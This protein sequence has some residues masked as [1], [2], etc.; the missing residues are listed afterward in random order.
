[1]R[2]K[3]CCVKNLFFCNFTID[4]IQKKKKNAMADAGTKDEKED[5]AGGNKT[6]FLTLLRLVRK[7][8]LSI[9]V[10]DN[11]YENPMKMRNSVLEQDFRVFGNYPGMRTICNGRTQTNDSTVFTTKNN[12]F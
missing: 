10:V 5:A 6:A 8:S 1:M 2:K 11:F 12:T 3:K 4:P 9:V 7:P